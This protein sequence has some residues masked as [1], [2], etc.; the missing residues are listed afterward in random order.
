MPMLFYIYAQRVLNKK[1]ESKLATSDDD[2]ITSVL[3]NCEGWKFGERQGD[4]AVTQR[5][6]PG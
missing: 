2:I 5:A 4:D 1:I 6:L 3:L